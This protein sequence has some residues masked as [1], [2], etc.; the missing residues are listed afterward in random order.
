MFL[1]GKAVY[2]YVFVSSGFLHGYKQ[3]DPIYS[4]QEVKLE[5]ISGQ[6]HT[7]IMVVC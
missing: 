6:R 3:C 5:P 2:V 4:Q 7:K 1:G